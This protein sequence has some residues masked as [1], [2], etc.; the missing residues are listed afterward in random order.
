MPL[1]RSTASEL[2]DD[3]A[4]T[5]PELRAT[6]R[7]L[8]RINRFLGG[9][10]IVRAYLDRIL[11]VWR[12]RRASGRD[13]LTLLDVATGGADVPIAAVAW[14]ERRGIPVR[15]VAVD[16]HPTIVRLAR[17]N[18]A[19]HPSITVIQGDARTLPFADGSFDVCLCSLALHH[20]TP[21]E[22]LALLGHLD[23][24]A[25][26]GFMAADLLRCASG[27]GGTWLVTRFF[28]PLIRHDG[29][30]SVRRALS[31]GEYL[32][33]AEATRIPGIRVMRQPFFRVALA[34][35]G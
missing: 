26:I 19:S 27:Y 23:R 28:S 7:D 2:M 6:L 15:V 13:S 17:A 33:L 22:G 18:V 16:H 34:R 35:I 3:P 30:L 21:D 29:P 32:R 4:R 12:A 14:G 8:G 20:L 31:W 5:P 24:L 10:A 1:Q 25:R 11:P 9:H